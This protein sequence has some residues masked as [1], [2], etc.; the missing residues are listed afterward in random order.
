MCVCVWQANSSAERYF[1]LLFLEEK[2]RIN[3]SFNGSGKK[4]RNNIESK[5]SCVTLAKSVEMMQAMVDRKLW[6]RGQRLL[7]VQAASS[8]FFVLHVVK[9]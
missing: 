7:P 9:G 2:T 1:L 8:C 3:Q 6:W 5:S 4:R